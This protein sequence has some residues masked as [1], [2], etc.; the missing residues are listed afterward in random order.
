MHIINGDS[1]AGSLKQAFRIP[2]EE[3]LVFRD[4]LSC[5][6]L[7]AYSDMDSWSK[8]R[9]AYWTQVCAKQGFRAMDDIH[10]A[11]RDFYKDFDDLNSADVLTLWMG[12][13]LS[14]HLLMVF[15]VKLF[16]H[17]GLDF[18]RLLIRQY[19]RFGKRNS[20]VVGIGI[21]SPEQIKKQKPEAFTLDK[22]RISFCLEVWEA[23]TAST[24]EKLMRILS[25]KETCLPLLNKALT[26]F[27]YRYPNI[28]NGLSR[29]DEIIL[30]AAK[31]YSPNTARAIG[32]TLG[33]DMCL[34]EDNIH[35]LDTVGDIYLF[36]RLKNMAKNHLNKPLLSLSIMDA[37]L[38]DTTVEVTDFGL[39]VLDGKHNV[40]QVNGIDDWVAGVHL[41]AST[42][43]TW[44][45][46]GDELVLNKIS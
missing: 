27:L 39:E 42:G 3:I 25:R 30:N 17:Y 29:F 12:C 46:Q 33:H 45:R 14:D 19:L 21:L 7:T 34:G 10:E 18:R 35:E 26:N 23:I 31:K 22:T 15:V 44:F 1:A 2:K 36:N 5:G 40:V 9:W 28:S 32:E 11:P 37:S 13:A 24:P 8:Y 6:G 41:D 38:R 20:T 4:V 43:E 16:D